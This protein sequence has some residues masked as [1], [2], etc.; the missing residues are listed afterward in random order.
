M[1]KKIIVIAT[2][3]VVVAVIAILGYAGWQRPGHPAFIDPSDQT[4]VMQGRQ[5]YANQCASCHG[6]NLQGQPNWRQRMPNGRLPAPPHDESG[7]T[8]H[9]PDNV[10]IDIVKNG[11]VPGRTAPEGYESDM[12]AYGNILSDAE[13][14]A[15]LAYVKSKWPPKVL[16]AQREITIREQR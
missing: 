15:V 9:H 6:A 4:L 7:H 13:I 2:A 12:P 3:L 11:L 14:I 1:D 5:V 8:W 16:E 10:L